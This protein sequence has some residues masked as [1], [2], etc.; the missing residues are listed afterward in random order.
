ML[1][2]LVLEFYEKYLVH[3]R[4]YLSK[5]EKREIIEEF[6]KH[7]QTVKH[8]LDENW[9]KFHKNLIQNAKNKQ[10]SKFVNVINEK[11]NK[12]FNILNNLKKEFESFYLNEVHE[13]ID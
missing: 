7:M 11:R 9:T 13:L 2:N 4:N 8:N 12:K 10:P 3:R 1:I 5:M 6:M